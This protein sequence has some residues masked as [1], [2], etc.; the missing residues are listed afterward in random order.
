[1]VRQFRHVKMLKRGGRAYDPG[2]AMKTAPGSLA[3]PCRACPIPNINL[4]AGW[5]NVPPVQACVY[6]FSF[7]ST[8]LNNIHQVAL[9]A[10]S[11]DGC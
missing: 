11:R 6:C 10:Y 2:G 7:I 4:P 5:E 3:I 1:M 9:H 8:A